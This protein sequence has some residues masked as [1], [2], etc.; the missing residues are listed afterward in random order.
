MPT[1]TVPDLEVATLDLDLIAPHPRNIRRDLGDLTELT[2]SIKSDGV[3]TPITVAPLTAETP[4]GDTVPDAAF[5]V[6][7]GHRRLAASREAGATTIPAVVRRDLKTDADA[8]I[9]M[10][11]ENLQRTDLTPVEEAAAY[12]QLRL[13]GV[14]APAIAKRTG[15]NRKTV[16]ARLSLLKLPEGTREKVHGRQVTLEEAAAMVEFAG[17]KAALRKL[18]AVAGTRDWTWTLAQV[19]TAAQAAVRREKATGDLKAAG[20]QVVTRAELGTSWWRNGLDEV[21][22]DLTPTD[23]GLPEDALDAEVDAARIARHAA[24]PHHAAEVL[25]TGTPRF[26]CL[27]PTVHKPAVGQRPDADGPDGDDEQMDLVRA[28]REAE[29][30]AVEQER[31]QLDADARLA[32]EVRRQFVEDTTSGRRGVLSAVAKAAIALYLAEQFLSADTYPEID[33]EGMAPFLGVDLPEEPDR[34]AKGYYNLRDA[35]EREV[36]GLVD[37]VVQ[38][39]G[40]HVGLLAVAAAHAES[41]LAVGRNWFPSSDM[42]AA[43]SPERGWLDLLDAL[44]YERTPWEQERLDLAAQ[45]A[46]DHAAEERAD[47]DDSEPADDDGGRDERGVVDVVESL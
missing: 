3:R 33:A 41:S 1:T 8:V 12:E 31:V 30:A 21:Y 16:D 35:W 36:S 18:E 7:A 32:A 43:G 2:A 15:R 6:I 14:K 38:R 27:D 45:F 42:L 4:D 17:D 23:L 10:L 5:F 13:A 44:G 46:L 20:V 28:A 29:R 47:E 37:A 25:D 40:G 34:T 9:E 26:V 24:C 11:V 19:R 22:R 39:R